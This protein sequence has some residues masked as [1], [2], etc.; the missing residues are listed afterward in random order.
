MKHQTVSILHGWAGGKWHTKEFV[1]S[2]KDAGFLISGNPSSADIIIAHSTGCYRL[3]TASKA[4]LIV[5]MGPPYWPNKSIFKRLL[6][7]K[8]HDNKLSAQKVSRGYVFKKTLWEAIYVFAKP[9]YT[10]VAL[11]NH[12]NLSSLENIMN[13]KILLIRNSD[14]CFCSSEIHQAAKKYPNIRYLQLAGAHDDFYLNHAPY[15]DLIKQEL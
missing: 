9:S 8:H 13:K 1:K 7:K 15:V 4:S 14:D 5:L 12:R 10:A 11:R 6:N 3:P 2:L